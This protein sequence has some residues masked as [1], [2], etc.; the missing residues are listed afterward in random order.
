[1][2]DAGLVVG[3]SCRGFVIVVGSGAMACATV[4]VVVVVGRV[5]GGNSRGC[6]RRSR[7]VVGE[8]G[9]VEWKRGAVESIVVV[10]EVDVGVVLMRGRDEGSCMVVERNR[11]QTEGV[12]G[13]WWSLGS[14]IARPYLWYRGP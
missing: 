10:V 11:L 1:M 8:E 5:V 6:W 13:R 3:R 14:R 9:V 4:V 12:E 2:L 7:L